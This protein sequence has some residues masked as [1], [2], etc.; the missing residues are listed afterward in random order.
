[1]KKYEYKIV[2]NL[3]SNYADEIELLNDLGKDGW[4]LCC[5]FV[6]HFNPFR[7]KW[8]FKRVLD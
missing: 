8:Y 7:E 6:D 5:K 1:M 3:P 2:K 4:E